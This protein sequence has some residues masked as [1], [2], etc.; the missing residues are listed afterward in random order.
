MKQH[1]TSHSMSMCCGVG[2]AVQ[3]LQRVEKIGEQEELDPLTLFLLLPELL[4]YINQSI[5]QS[6]TACYTR[7]LLPK[8][9]FLSLTLC[10][11]S[12]LSFCM[13]RQDMVRYS[14]WFVL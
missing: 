4:K 8:S 5:I 6:I 12:F 7:H 9:Y 13:N 1:L 2:L 3:V 10:S 14:V 11:L